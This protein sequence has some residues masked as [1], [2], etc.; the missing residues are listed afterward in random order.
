[1]LNGVRTKL[2]RTFVAFDVVSTKFGNALF[3]AIP[4][5]Y[6]KYALGRINVK[7]SQPSHVSSAPLVN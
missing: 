1:M 4:R 7:F 3:D 5:I 2:F 6:A